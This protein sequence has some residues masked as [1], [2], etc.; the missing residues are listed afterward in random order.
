MLRMLM[1]GGPPFQISTIV[2]WPLESSCPRLVWGNMGG[3]WARN[4]GRK[5]NI[6]GETIATRHPSVHSRVSRREKVLNASP[7][8]V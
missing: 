3:V 6:G 7:R 8:R 4:S 5:K 2:I 1:A